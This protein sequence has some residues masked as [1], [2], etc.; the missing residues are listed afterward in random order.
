MSDVTHN[1]FRPVDGCCHEAHF[2]RKIEEMHQSLI[3]YLP[4]TDQLNKLQVTNPIWSL[5]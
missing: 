2:L 1:I 5:M 3:Q 4:S